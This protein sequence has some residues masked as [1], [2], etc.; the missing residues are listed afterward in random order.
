MVKAAFPKPVSSL[1]F[2]VVLL[3]V[4][5]FVIFRGG[6][7]LTEIPYRRAISRLRSGALG[8]LPVISLRFG[9]RAGSRLTGD[10]ERGIC[11]RDTGGVLL[12]EAG[13]EQ[14]DVSVSLC[15]AI[16][17]G[18]RRLPSTSLPPPWM[19]SLVAQLYQLHL[20]SGRPTVGTSKICRSVDALGEK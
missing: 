1:P 12:G 8:L 16:V 3:L 6:V 5:A 10:F 18:C 7:P 9:L 15:H 14:S 2:A 4:L 19:F 11:R 20:A 17:A 13:R